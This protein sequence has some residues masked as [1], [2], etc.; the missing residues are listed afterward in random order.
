M[1]VFPRKFTKGDTN[2]VLLHL[3]VSNN[4]DTVLDGEA[5]FDVKAPDGSTYTMTEP[6]SIPP[7]KERNIYIPYSPVEFH[8][9]TYTIDGRFRHDDTVI[10]SRT[11]EHDQFT[12]TAQTSEK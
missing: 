3:R 2:V 7:D 5:V 4:G 12:V 1:S 9:G 6:L 10:Q 11:K 8:P